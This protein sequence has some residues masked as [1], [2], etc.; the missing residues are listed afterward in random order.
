MLM[1]PEAKV[2]RPRGAIPVLW[3][4]APEFPP[5]SREVV[6]RG[7]DYVNRMARRKLFAHISGLGPMREP[8]PMGVVVAKGQPTPAQEAAGARARVVFPKEGGWDW[9]RLE[10]LPDWFALNARVP[11]GI[12]G[13]ARREN[14]IRHEVMHL[15][16]FCH[17]A[18]RASIMHPAFSS[19]W[20]FWFGRSLSTEE[21]A[22]LWRAYP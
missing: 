15:L 21:R 2:V 14:H 9:A 4:F 20:R 6:R 1:L 8:P 13:D 17:S 11:F 10:L 5:G 22:E 3:G 18:R 12:F 19:P 7:F 16:G